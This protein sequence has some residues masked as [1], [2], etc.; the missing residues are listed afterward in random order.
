MLTYIDGLRNT[1]DNN[2]YF[3]RARLEAMFQP[4]LKVLFIYVRERD[5]QYSFKDTKEKIIRSWKFVLF[6]SPQ[7]EVLIGLS[8]GV[9]WKS[10][11]L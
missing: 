3:I 8:L 9:K 6:F 2:F 5:E 10:Y 7:S 1:K 11:E 4:W